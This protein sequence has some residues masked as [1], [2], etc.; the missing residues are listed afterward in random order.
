MLSTGIDLV[1]VERL[2]SV[3]QRYGARFLERIFTSQ[4]LSE[5]GRNPASLAAR[6]A[7][8]EAVSKALGTGIGDMT[9]LD[10]EVLR[11]PA[12]EPTLH[13]HGK[14]AELARDLKLD[15]WS[16][17]LSHTQ[18]HAIAM[19]VALSTGGEDKQ[20]ARRRPS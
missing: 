14:A 11:G 17:S 16:I 6:F 1:E 8:K 5:A 7:A 20:D 12:R 4:E 18:T 9:W 13:L 2:Q 3:A 10:I 15:S 19:V